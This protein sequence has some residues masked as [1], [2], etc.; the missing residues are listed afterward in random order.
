MRKIGVNRSDS[1]DFS[2]E[3]RDDDRPSIRAAMTRG[4]HRHEQDSATIEDRARR[5]TGR[6]V[7]FEPSAPMAEQAAQQ[8]STSRQSAAENTAG[9]E[10]RHAARTSTHH[11]IE[12]ATR[13]A[14][15]TTSSLQSASLTAVE[16][17]DAAQTRMLIEAVVAALAAQ[18]MPG[19]IQQESRSADP[20][21]DHAGS[22]STSSNFSVIATP[23]FATHLLTKQTPTIPPRPRTAQI[24]PFLQDQEACVYTTP[25]VQPPSIPPRQPTTQP[26]Q[27]SA[28]YTLPQG[29]LPIQIPPRYIQG[30]DVREWLADFEDF[31]QTTR[32]PDKFG[33]LWSYLER[34][35]KELLEFVITGQTSD[36][37]YESAKRELICMSGTRE[38]SQSEYRN[39]F[40]DRKQR[41]GEPVKRFFNELCRLSRKAF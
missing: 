19:A 35:T 21:E 30:M 12:E 18:R 15:S 37:R 23:P 17:Q 5:Y 33:V 32:T 34:N 20:V 10:D 36:E 3:Q 11:E 6:R 41:Q 24:N 8:P 13:T 31:V 38:K 28:N 16:T 2:N 9:L 25:Q 27:Y 39:E 7:E 26:T 40:R 1:K 4:Q 14:R 22:A 29:H